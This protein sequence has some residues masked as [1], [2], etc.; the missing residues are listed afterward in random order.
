[1]ED[2]PL[3][4]KSNRL[5]GLSIKVFFGNFIVVILLGIYIAKLIY[6]DSSLHRLGQLERQERLLKQEIER[7]KEENARLHKLYLEWSDVRDSSNP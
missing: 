3:I 7:L 4:K 2:I 5:F 1:M 6:G